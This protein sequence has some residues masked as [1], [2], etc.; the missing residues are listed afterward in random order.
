M[1][2]ENPF[3]NSAIVIQGEKSET[4][5]LPD[6]PVTNEVTEDDSEPE[7]SAGKNGAAQLQPPPIENDVNDEST[8]ENSTETETDDSDETETGENDEPEYDPT[9]P[10]TYGISIEP[11]WD[12]DVLEYQGHKLGVHI[13]KQ[14]ALTGFTMATGV[15]IPDAVKQNMVSMFAYNH[16]SPISY[17]FL[18][19]R[20]MNPL[21]AEFTEESFGE[22]I[23]MLIDASGKRILEAIEAKQAAE[24]KATKRK[25][26]P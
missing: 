11:D 25:K 13:P 7:K 14:Q 2:S 16:I 15:Y 12:G 3:E 26:R 22:V 8:G 1:T 10:P 17:S 18:M 19:T 4:T 9:K 21:D 6:P 5:T 24:K 23:R 20:L